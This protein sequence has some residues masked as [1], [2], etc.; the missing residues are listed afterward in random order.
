MGLQEE[1]AEREQIL[2]REE[3]DGHCDLRPARREMVE[4]LKGDGADVGGGLF[5]GRP[6]VMIDIEESTQALLEQDNEIVL[7]YEDI[8]K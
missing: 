1:L 2:R 6:E 8:G 7:D 4:V 5:E 3:V